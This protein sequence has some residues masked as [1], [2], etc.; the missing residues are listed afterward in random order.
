M[1]ERSYVRSGRQGKSIAV[2]F[3]VILH[4]GASS[5]SMS[6][7]GLVM[8]SNWKQDLFAP[9]QCRV[10]SVVVFLRSVLCLFVSG[11]EVSLPSGSSSK[12]Y[13]LAVCRSILAKLSF[14]LR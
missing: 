1:E 6:V 5:V 13:A 2:L 7:N 11:S 9:N 12:N 14:V 10:V 8:C 4:R 3:C